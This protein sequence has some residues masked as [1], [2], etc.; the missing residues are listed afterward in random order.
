MS[1]AVEVARRAGVSEVEW[2]LAAREAE[3]AL[4]RMLIAGREAGDL[5][6]EGRPRAQLTGPNE[7]TGPTSSRA[8]RSTNKTPT[9]AHQGDM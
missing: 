3:R 8:Q 7:L 9:V 5:T 6:G 4:G 1:A 2:M